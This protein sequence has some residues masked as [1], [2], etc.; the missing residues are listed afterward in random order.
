[1]NP[2]KITLLTLG[3]WIVLTILYV[4]YFVEDVSE[5]PLVVAVDSFYLLP[6]VCIITFVTSLFFYRSWI[7]NNR[8]KFAISSL[9]LI[10]WYLFF[11]YGKL[12]SCPDIT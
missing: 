12:S 4:R 9:I 2:I 7:S 3:A 5:E 1:M 8:I 6:L 11:L 10:A